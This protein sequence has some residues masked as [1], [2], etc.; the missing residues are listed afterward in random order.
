MLQNLRP[1]GWHQLSKILKSDLGSVSK[2]SSEQSCAIAGVSDDLDLQ[3]AS[4]ALELL[5]HG[6]LRNH[7]IAVAITDRKI[8]LLY[9]D[10]SIIVKLISSAMIHALY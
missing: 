7:V 5:W 4:Y 9:Y 8:E 6:G 1:R 10:R 2:K 3:C